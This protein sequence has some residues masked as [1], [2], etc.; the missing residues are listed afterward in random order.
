MLDV[1][2][3]R[4]TAIEPA[5]AVTASGAK[6]EVEWRES[7][8]RLAEARYRTLIEQL[9]AVTFLASLAGGQ[10][11]I[12]VSPQIESLLGFTQQEWVSDPILWYRQTHPDDRERLSLGFAAACSTGQQFRCV[13]RVHTR[14]GAERRVH[15]EARF[16]RDER[17]QLLFLQ[18]VGFDVTEQ[19]RAQEAREQLI[20]ERA[21]R[22]EADRERR[23]LQE[24]FTSLPAAISVLTGPEHIIE[25]SNPVAAELAGTEQASVGKPWADVFPELGGA[26]IAALDR[27]RATGESQVVREYRTDSPRWGGERFFNLVCQ[28][29]R[30]A[31][32]NVALLVTHVVDVTEQVRA[33]QEV[34]EA[35]QLRE[36]FLSIAAHEL[37]NPL[38]ALRLSLQFASRRAQRA[39]EPLATE[40]VTS[41][42]GR[43]SA[44][45]DRLLRLVENLLDVSRISAGRMTLEIEDVDLTAVVRDV[46]ERSASE[47]G[48]QQVVIRAD[49]SVVG[50]WDHL[51]LE[52]VVTNFV[53]NAIK[54]GEGKPIEISVHRDDGIA[55]LCVRDHGIGL[56]PEEQG[57][58]F[59]KFERAASL[60]NHGGL[61]LGLWITRQ[62]VDALGGRVMVHSR[63]GEGSEFIVELPL[64]MHSTQAGR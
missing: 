40:W 54:Y 45:T 32:G 27:A 37:R 30:D 55:R 43:A 63:P 52:Q 12:Y 61:G 49:T 46:V 3:A 15:I 6:P 2:A 24:V 9:P 47:L 21:A 29:L 13:V 11:E 31:V 7:R 60:R 5:A 51:R 33:R 18:G 57:R 58:I 25:F 23:R 44:Q 64:E 22:A 56:T 50:A 10:N 41:N 35:L 14:D 1:V 28:P 62:I 16:V 17:G 8:L 53:S 20:R 36:D 19:F 26:A 42:L 59:E 39:T 38:S 4:S 48:Q 34:E